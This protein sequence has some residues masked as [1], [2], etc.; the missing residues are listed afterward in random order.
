[1]QCDT[2][3]RRVVSNRFP[4]RGSRANTRPPRIVY[5]EQGSGF[6][7]ALSVLAIAIGLLERRGYETHAVLT[8]RDARAER[9]LRAVC[10]NVHVLSYKRRPQAV[11]DQLERLAAKTRWLKWPYLAL[12]IAREGVEKAQW[13]I[14][15]HWLLRRV[16]PDIVH[17]NNGPEYNTGAM[18][19]ARAQGFRTVVHVR[20]E[21]HRTFLARLV[22]AVCHAEIF[23]SEH[24]RDRMASRNRNAIIVYDGLDKR[25]WP[26]PAARRSDGVLRVGHLGMFTPWKGQDV[27]LRAAL[28]VAEKARDV[29]FHLLGD[30]IDKA[31]APYAARLKATAQASPYADRI[32]FRG[33]QV[34]VRKALSELDVL[35][36][37]SLDPEPL[38]TVV[39]EGMASGLA[40]V[41]SN[42]GGPL[43][44]IRDGVDGLLIPP[45]DTAA[46]AWVIEDLIRNPTRIRALGRAARRRFEEVF[47]AERM[48][49]Q[50]A[51]LY[52]GLLRRQG[53]V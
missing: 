49:E 18:L 24:L 31:A 3:E 16:R 7:G 15:L 53:T 13:L 43:E 1:M 32:C 47:T 17:G 41:A 14:R 6:G 37:S 36:H 50:L 11:K 10:P 23:V 34:D 30:V 5:I 46:M 12:V 42:R 19:L 4:G 28:K 22:E 48:V 33:F 26:A 29:E 39:L 8:Y 45:G 25:D 9:T 20:S 2:E 21:D 44:M 51:L 52:E 35:V 40:I 38:G 27:F